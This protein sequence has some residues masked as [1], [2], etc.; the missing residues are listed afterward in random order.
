[1]LPWLYEPRRA[2]HEGLTVIVHLLDILR[3]K[4]QLRFILCIVPLPLGDRQWYYVVPSP[5]PHYLSSGDTSQWCTCLFLVLPLGL[6]KYCVCIAVQMSFPPPS[7]FL[8]LW[9]VVFNLCIYVYQSIPFRWKWKLTSLSSYLIDLLRYSCWVETC[10]YVPDWMLSVQPRLCS[11]WIKSYHCC[12]VLSENLCLLHYLSVPPTFAM[13]LLSGNICLFFR[14][15]GVSTQSSIPVG[16][17]VI[18][19][20]LFWFPA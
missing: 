18:N 19:T 10:V 5:F 17:K 4:W 7:V 12:H 3:F 14:S 2:S 11:D 13:F 16:L 9:S 15:D 1:M 6:T 20:V 8:L